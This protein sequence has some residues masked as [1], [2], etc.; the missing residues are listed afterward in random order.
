MV[1]MGLLCGFQLVGAAGSEAGEKPASLT[2]ADFE[3]AALVS[4]DIQEMKPHKVRDE[5][6]LAE[7][8]QGGST[9]A[10][11]NAALDHFF[12]TTLPNAGKIAGLF[13]AKNI[14]VIIVHWGFRLRGG[15]DLDPAV[16][17]GFIKNMGPNWKNWGHGVND[18]GSQPAAAL[19][20]SDTDYVIAK[21]AQDAFTSSNINFVLQNL[22][23]KTLFMMGGHTNGCL[24]GTAK[25][26]VAAGYR[27]ICIEDATFDLGEKRRLDGISR[28]GFA[29]VVKTAEVESAMSLAPA[30]PKDTGK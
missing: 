21:T 3:N 15:M 2:A 27:T 14:P 10:D 22:G 19:K 20:V 8:R 30:Q 12:N 23:V 29:L 26:A 6:I 9:A 7:H 13:R 17:R 1:F 4:V 11:Q 16:R 24:L 28:S 18:A 25:S 5:D